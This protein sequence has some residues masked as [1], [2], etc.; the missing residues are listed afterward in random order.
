MS[1]ENDTELLSVESPLPSGGIHDSGENGAVCAP[2][3][4]ALLVHPTTPTRQAQSRVHKPS[5]CMRRLFPNL[6]FVPPA[7]TPVD[8]N[9]WLVAT[10]ETFVCTTR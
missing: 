2:V 9:H 6:G 8:L 1:F 3:L 10:R 5:T 4:L 7:C